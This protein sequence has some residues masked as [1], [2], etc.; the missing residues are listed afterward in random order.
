MTLQYRRDNDC[1]FNKTR[2]DTLVATLIKLPEEDDPEMPRELL[3]SIPYP[4]LRSLLS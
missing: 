1:L 2:Y 3:S 4:Q